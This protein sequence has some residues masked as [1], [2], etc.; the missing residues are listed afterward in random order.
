[1]LEQ[2]KQDVENLAAAWKLPIA[3][4]ELSLNWIPQKFY[5][6]RE[7]LSRCSKVYAIQH[8]YDS[9]DFSSL[10]LERDG[11]IILYGGGF[12]YDGVLNPKKHPDNYY[13]RLATV[14][15]EQALCRYRAISE[16]YSTFVSGKDG[17]VTLK[18]RGWNDSVRTKRFII[19]LVENY[20]PLQMN[21]VM[22]FN[23]LARI[24]D[25]VYLEARNI[26]LTFWKAED[27]HAY[28]WA[29]GERMRLILEDGWSGEVYADIPFYGE[30]NAEVK[31]KLLASISYA[32]L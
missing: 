5:Y 26:A 21:L 18:V 32:F 11:H 17:T 15:I 2:V 16:K 7:L 6:T 19:V 28:I 9:S 13:E 4:R 30:W 31:E 8:I 3:V 25:R 1:M 10:L 12:T 24:T 27:I 20:Q 14:L 23:R 22:L 29:A